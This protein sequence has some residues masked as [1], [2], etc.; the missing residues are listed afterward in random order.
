MVFSGNGGKSFLVL[1][2]FGILLGFSYLMAPGY[3]F[4]ITLIV[5]AIFIVALIRPEYGFYLLIFILIE[6]MV[7]FF[8][9]IPPYYEVRIFPYYLPIVATAASLIAAK[10]A[11]REAL[12][13]TPVTALLWLT[14][15]GEIISSIWAPNREMAFWLSVMLLLNLMLYYV[16]INIIVSENILKTSIKVW[17]AAGSA[18]AAGV[19][20]SQWIDE[21]KIIF[22]TNHSGIKLA[23]QE[24]LTRPS[25]FAGVDHAAGF[26]S[27]A[28][29][30]TLGSMMYEKRWKVKAV[31]LLIMLFLLYSVVLTTSRG[32]IIGLAGA[33]IFFISVHAGFKS[34]FI[35]YSLIL[36]I[37]T[38]FLVLLAKPGFIDRMLIGFGYTGQLM[39]SDTESYHGTEAA[40]ESGEGFSGMEIRMLWWKNA[41]EEMI[42][43][44]FKLFFGLG[45]GGFY[46]YSQGGTT[47]SS[48]EVNSISFAFFYDIGIFGIILFILLIYLIVSNLYHYLKNAKRSYSYYMLLA[49]TTAMIAETGIHGLI[50][51]DLTSY[52]A[53]F[54][55]FPLGF[56]MAVLNIV[57]KENVQPIESDRYV[58]DVEDKQIA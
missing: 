47:V 45:I 3:I 27:T 57:K 52:G 25:G 29:F 2:L 1:W 30:L 33:Y 17:I 9:V 39:F 43:H 26:V 24:H 51:Y 36:M 13:K 49:A 5:C 4:A 58:N 15:I 22:F 35:R 42:R 48:P 44:P 14:V 20:T 12:R 32:V 54:F 8:I 18:T 31:Y 38:V 10:I 53:K 6:E 7:H 34:K 55:W 56:T 40:T 21:L 46:Y 19:I 11:N 41:L 23:F 16:I 28:F 50:D 37:S